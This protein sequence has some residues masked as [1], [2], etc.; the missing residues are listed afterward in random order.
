MSFS[1]KTVSRTPATKGPSE[2]LPRRSTRAAKSNTPAT[3]PA[4][5]G[6]AVFLRPLSR[7]VP[8]ANLALFKSSSCQNITSSRS[9]SQS[10]L[11]S[12]GSNKEVKGRKVAA[13]KPTSTVTLPSAVLRESNS[14]VSGNGERMCANS[15]LLSRVEKEKKQYE[16]RISELAHI[17]EARK[18]EI[19]RLSMEL[20][21]LRES[22]SST[23]SLKRRPVDTTASTSGV[24][25]TCQT[26]SPASSSLGTTTRMTPG[27]ATSDTTGFDFSD[28]QSF[29][30]DASCFLLA[31]TASCDDETIQ[32]SSGLSTLPI[33]TQP[34]VAKLE[35][36]IHEMEEANFTTTEELQATMEELCDLQ[37]TLECTQ[38]DNR[39]LAF[40]RAILLE[41]LCTQ[42]AKLE[43]CR[44]QIN[45]LKHLLVT[46]PHIDSREANY[47]ELYASVEEEKQILL[48]QNNDLAQRSETL[49]AE[50]RQ[51]SDKVEELTKEIEHLR[52]EASAVA[53][54]M[55][56]TSTT[57]ATQT[58]PDA[59]DSAETKENR[60]VA[61]VQS[62]LEA[63]LDSLF[64][65]VGLWKEKY[66]LEKAAHERNATEWRLY[67]RDLL[68]TVQVADG[69]K[70][71]SEFEVARIT[72]EAHN[73]RGQV[74]VFLFLSFFTNITL[75]L[76]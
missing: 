42:T 69:I 12:R 72:L 10:S 50:C 47:V 5:K 25:E 65:Q 56:L 26:R 32:T 39:N 21:N 13:R 29:L 8:R 55:V 20:R 31:R 74:S 57:D 44:L 11:D 45:Q 66:E 38:E 68:K 51:L 19:E 71:E 64:R 36:R 15:D 16:S 76:S 6:D 23:G 17:A 63:Q 49:D 7:S 34:S 53:A 28:Q 2:S 54:A 73:L 37:R 60:P 1:G 33:P 41:S 4:V 30:S 35:D 18:M 22:V 52:L 27:G 43:H 9:N 14:T 24:G 67:E 75:E 3:N 40:E 70:M 58:P 46:N 62:D 59:I 48:A 61:P